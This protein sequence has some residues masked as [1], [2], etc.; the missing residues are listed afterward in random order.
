M[1]SASLASQG[2]QRSRRTSEQ[3]KVEI[4]NVQEKNLDDSTIKGRE[5][6]NDNSSIQNDNIDS[7]KVG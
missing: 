4:E 2:E 1:S 6:Q 7:S 5:N 3:Q